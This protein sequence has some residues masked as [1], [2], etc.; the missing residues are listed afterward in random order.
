MITVIRT[1][2]SVDEKSEEAARQFILSFRRRLPYKRAGRGPKGSKKTS[3]CP[4]CGSVGDYDFHG[5][6]KYCMSCGYDRVFERF[7]DLARGDITR[8]NPVDRQRLYRLLFYLA[9]T[10]KAEIQF[11]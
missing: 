5:R 1:K 7:L 8:G 10:H 4:H 6:T 9:D 2:P 11:C 3:P